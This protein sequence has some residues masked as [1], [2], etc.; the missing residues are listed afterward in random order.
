MHCGA[1]CFQMIRAW[2]APM[3]NAAST[4]MLSRTDSATDRITRTTVG[5]REIARAPITVQKLAPSTST[6][7]Y[8]SIRPGRARSISTNLSLKRSNLPPK[9]PLISPHTPPMSVPTTTELTAMNS[10]ARAP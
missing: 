4:Y 7:R 6:S 2:E 8:A 1:M 10:E 5:T 9:N 3:I